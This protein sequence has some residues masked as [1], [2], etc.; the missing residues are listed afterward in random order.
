MGKPKVIWSPFKGSQTKFLSCP[1]WECLLH[2][3][4]GGGKTDVLVM[5]F[6][7][8]VGKGF[9]ADY[10]GLLLREATTELGDVISKTKKWIPR[11]F[12]SAKYNGSRKIWTFADGETLWMNYARTIDDY[13]QYHGHEYPWIGWEELTNHAMDTIYLKLMSCNRSSNEDIPLK[14]RATCNPSGPGHQCVKA[15]FIDKT[16]QGKIYR[17]KVIFE[18]PDE[19]G[20]MVKQEVTIARTHVQSFASENKALMRADPM[21]MA[22]IFSLSQDNPM[23]KKAWIDGS[24]DLTIGGFFTDVWDK[25]VHILPNF[26]IPYSWRLYRSFDWG[27]SKPWA[28][29]YGFESNGEQPEDPE[30]PYIPKGSVLI[31]TEIYGW[32]GTANEG[33]RATSQE[34]AERVSGVDNALLTEYKAKCYAGPADTAIWTVTDGVSI[35]SN[36]ATHGC[37][38]TKA[39]KG[40]GSR[41][42]GWAIMRQMLG[43]T[44][45]QDPEKPH[46]YF[47]DQA[48]HHIRTLPLMQRDKKKPEDIDTKLEDHAMDSLRY[49]LARKMVRLKQRKVGI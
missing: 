28:V 18:Y 8:N 10:K 7:Q 36:L 16:E 11:M 37:K 29:T 41:I 3:N 33:D 42:A 40:A 48:A 43:A 49:F 47:F 31:P 46:L 24:W 26:Q 35:A 17:E 12:P 22:K 4:R 13:E 39:Y 5:D 25:K 30:I 19:N 45:R 21:Y 27:S 20:D 1:V 14:Y 44:K 2:G 15:R 32:N 23:L 38:W 34:I 9:G 6:L